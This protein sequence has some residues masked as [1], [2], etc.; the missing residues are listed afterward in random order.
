MRRL[1]APSFASSA[2]S[3]LVSWSRNR[4]MPFASCW[5][6]AARLGRCAT[7]C[8]QR[9][10]SSSRLFRRK[11][12][13]ARRSIGT[14]VETPGA[15][16]APTRIGACRAS[17]PKPS[18]RQRTKACRLPHAT[19]AADSH[20]RH[21]LDAYRPRRAIRGQRHA[22]RQG[23]VRLRAWICPIASSGRT[24]LAR[25]STDCGNPCR[26]TSVRFACV[27]ASALPC[28]PTTVTPLT[29]CSGSPALPCNVPGIR[30]TDTPSATRAL[31]AGQASSPTFLRPAP[32]V[33]RSVAEARTIRCQSCIGR[34][35]ANGIEIHDPDT[36]LCNQRQAV[37]VTRRGR[38]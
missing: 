14:R 8:L 12:C 17:G 16:R 11:S 4:G 27:R 29:N 19:S 7:L 3:V 22:S 13:T 20:A 36:I 24:W 38:V 30:G 2:S 31:S 34:H 37:R 26:L 9:A 28:V 33:Q 18:V 23:R 25:C 21:C 35:G 15:A 6:V 1:S 10:I 5:W 32:R